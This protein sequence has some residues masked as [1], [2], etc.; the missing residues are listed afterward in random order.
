VF[1]KFPK[2]HRKIL[3]EDFSVKE[4]KEDIFK[5]QLGMKVYTKLV[6]IMELE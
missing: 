2:Y 4:G 5:S 6:M 3:L 1:D